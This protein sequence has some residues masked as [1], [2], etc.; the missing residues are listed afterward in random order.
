[1][2]WGQHEGIASADGS[3]KSLTNKTGVVRHVGISCAVEFD[4]PI[5]G[6]HNCNGNTLD[7]RGWNVP[8]ASLR[9][10]EPVKDVIKN[11]FGA[12]G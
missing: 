12:V 7:G 6:M 11:L 3:I 4:E 1:M 8:V 2:V 10:L 5:F 9:K